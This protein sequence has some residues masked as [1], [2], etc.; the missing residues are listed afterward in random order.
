MKEETPPH[1]DA[2]VILMGSFPEEFFRHATR[3]NQAL[4]RLII[5]EESMGPFS[6]LEE[7][8]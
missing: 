5:V 2:M 8:G 6:M 1:A 4:G 3:G 7:R